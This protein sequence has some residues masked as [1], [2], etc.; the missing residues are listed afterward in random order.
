VWLAGCAEFP[1]GHAEDAGLVEAFADA[2]VDAA[3][4]V[5]DDPTVDWEAR[6]LVVIRETWDY[7]A[8]L[9]DFLTWVERLEG[10]LVNA[11][12]V[13]RWNH[14]KGYLVAL[15]DAGVAVVPTILVARGSDAPAIPAW[16][17]LVVKPAVGVGGD[18]AERLPAGSQALARHLAA[19][20]RSGD[21]LLQPYLPS[22]EDG[23]ETSLVLAA[24]TVSHA[25]RKVPAPGEFRVHEHRGGTY[26]RV[27]PEQ[28]QVELATVAL[29]VAE[30]LA[31]AS[32]AY[33]RADLVAG[34]EGAS[35]LMEL[36][37][38][39]PSLYLHHAPGTAAGVV[40]GLLAA[41]W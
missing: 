14:H 41:R 24:G 4:A 28:E 34:P 5:W 7:P 27:E 1:D 21:L 40:A 2:G 6:E 22:I 32:T 19:L 17:E 39:E 37:L 36:E 31:G 33:A 29:A 18:G 8:A 20:D 15:A 3:W 16:P 11:A 30:D 10:R 13:I 38:I 23:G 26:R 12:P 35:L 25:V 9:E